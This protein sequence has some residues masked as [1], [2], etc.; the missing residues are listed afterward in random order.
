M[1][2]KVLISFLYVVP[3]L[4]CIWQLDKVSRENKRLS[5]EC[6][7]LQQELINQTNEKIKFQDNFNT[8]PVK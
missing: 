3:F 6:Q 7:R 2:V 4:I 1:D 5:Q 8:D